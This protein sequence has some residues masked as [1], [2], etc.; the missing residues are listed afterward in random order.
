MPQRL[1][2]ALAGME[3][4]IRGW[5]ADA[6]SGGN[7]NTGA[8]GAHAL[9]GALHTGTLAETQAPWA[10]TLG[11]LAAHTANQAAHHSPVTAGT[12]IGLSGQQVS[13]ANG[14]AQYQVPVTGASPFTPAW[15]ALSGMAGAGLTF[16]SGAFA[17]G[18]GTLITVGADA[19][20]ITAGSNYQFVGTGS[21]TAAAWQ[22]LST[23]AGNGLTHSA[24]VL[25]VGVSGLGLSVG[26]DAVTLTSSSNPGAAASI[27]ASSAAG[28]VQ[29]VQVA[30]NATFASGF[31]G[32]GYRVDY[33]ITEASKASAEFDNLTVRGRMRVYE[34]LIQQIRATNG[35]VFVT[36]TGK[37]KAVTA[38]TDPT[39]TVNGSQLTFN[40]SNATLATALYTITTSD[41][42]EDASDKSLYH[43]FLAGDLIRAQQTEWNGSAFAGVYQSDLE[44][45]GVTDLYT[46]TAARVSSGTS[47]A[48]VGYDYARLGSATDSTR[49]GTIYLTS[50]DSN[51]PFIDILDGV[52]AH[53]G[54]NASGNVKVRLGKLSG[55]SDAYFGTLS[56]YGLYSDNVYLRGSIYAT[57]GIFSGTVYASAGTFTGTVTASAGTIGGWTIGASTLTGGN[58][59]LNSA[60]ALVLGTGNDVVELDAAD[61]THR[62]WVGNATA[63]SAPFRVTKAGA[64][65]ATSG[66]VGGWT[67][68]STA[69]TSGSGGSTVGLDAGG[70][71]PAI[72]AGSAT[73][74]SAPFRVTQ[75][76]VLYADGADVRGAITA[77]SGSITGFLTLGTSGG[78]YQGTGTAGTPTT[79]LK[80]WNDSG[81]GRIGGYNGGALQWYAS[82][83]GYFYSGSGTMRIGAD[84]LR[85]TM[86][87]YDGDYDDYRTIKWLPSIDGAD[88]SRLDFDYR[89]DIVA[90][91]ASDSSKATLDLT[92]RVNAG[93]YDTRE[94][95]TQIAATNWNGTT[96]NRAELAVIT[97]SSADSYQRIIRMTQDVLQIDL[98]SAPSGNPP[99]GYIFVWWESGATMKTKDSGGTTR[100]VTFS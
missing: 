63:A 41:S 59:T 87:T 77:S 80:I 49:R 52:Q 66:T 60:G 48:A 86:G 53:S 47:A 85:L 84:D 36:S 23:L 31:A 78:I 50:D 6:I 46:F 57:S 9:S 26:A 69:L 56:G 7:A 16:G 58:A 44:V 33:G 72:Y 38:S 67:L 83:A 5:I 29:L 90:Y 73:P 88:S 34:L 70:T 98:N 61:A 28:L 35:S 39:W 4:I 14:S 51:A 99:T 2:D 65:T 62:L 76:G 96:T 82:T 13:V 74:G 24:G 64:V 89:S 20:G 81:V 95:W 1:T 25:A 10:V 97:K 17:V 11:G 21:G 8:I 94:A 3:P 18:A 42:T 22:N 15:T 71:N 19:V 32:S 79:G 54:W 37:A 75:A 40:G 12:L 45:T 68:G 93:D 100:S 30:S 91:G 92:T 43:G 55:I 27:L